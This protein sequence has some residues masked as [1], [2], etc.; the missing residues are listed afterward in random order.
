LLPAFSVSPDFCDSG[1]TLD[2]P[3]DCGETCDIIYC[4]SDC[5]VIKVGPTNDIGP[6]DPTG[7]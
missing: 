5:D 2:P 3:A 1:K 7:N 4:E 6:A